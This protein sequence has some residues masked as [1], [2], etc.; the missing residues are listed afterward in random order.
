MP[1]R[2]S[3]EQILDWTLATEINT[4]TLEST[5]ISLE[6]A[7]NAVDQERRYRLSL[8]QHA[9]VDRASILRSEVTLELAK[10]DEIDTMPDRIDLSSTDK[11]DVKIPYKPEGSFYPFSI[12]TSA[13]KDYSGDDKAYNNLR[14]Q[15][16]S[17]VFSPELAERKG[18]HQSQ[19][20]RAIRRLVG[21]ADPSVTH[22]GWYEESLI[23][24]AAKGVRVEPGKGITFVDPEK[25]VHALEPKPRRSG[26][27]FRVTPVLLEYVRRLTLQ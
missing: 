23:A 27:D 20:G 18:V 17:T 4:G 7:E 13:M 16:V 6:V 19:A 24:A 3:N 15:V 21:L 1:E 8:I 11:I 22:C 12:I 2:C 9:M 14:K 5:G 25:T 26:I 10:L